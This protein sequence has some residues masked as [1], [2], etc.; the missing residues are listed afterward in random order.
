[1]KTKFLAD[2]DSVAMFGIDQILARRTCST[3]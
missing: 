2:V 1:V 3:G